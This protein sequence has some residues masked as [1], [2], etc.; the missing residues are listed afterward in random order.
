MQLS[1]FAVLSGR[2]ALTYG[3]STIGASAGRNSNSR[4]LHAGE[5]SHTKL[6]AASP[7]FDASLY[8]EVKC[9]TMGGASTAFSTALTNFMGIALS[10]SPTSTAASNYITG[11]GRTTNSD[12]CCVTLSMDISSY[13]GTHYLHLVDNKLSGTWAW[14]TFTGCWLS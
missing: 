12:N 4:N 13:T 6:V 10:T 1:F 7:A 3:D 5:R 14:I 9:S 8:S 11:V 2:L